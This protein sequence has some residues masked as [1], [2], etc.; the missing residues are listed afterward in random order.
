MVEPDF[1]ENDHDLSSDVGDTGSC[2][3]VVARAHTHSGTANRALFTPSRLP[4]PTR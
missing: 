1:I 4:N 2:P 3:P